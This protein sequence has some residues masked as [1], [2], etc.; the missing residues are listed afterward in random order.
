[1]FHSTKRFG[2]LFERG[3]YSVDIQQEKKYLFSSDLPADLS[4]YDGLWK[5]NP[6]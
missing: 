1:M 3:G 6:M 2:L 5:N 4:V